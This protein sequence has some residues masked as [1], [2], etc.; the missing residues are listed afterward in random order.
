VENVNK[1]GPVLPKYTGEKPE[2]WREGRHQ[3]SI[4]EYQYLSTYRVEHEVSS[5]A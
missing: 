3:L 1:K 2:G 5:G 4:T